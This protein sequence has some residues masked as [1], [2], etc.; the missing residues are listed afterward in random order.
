M[1]YQPRTLLALQLLAFRLMSS[2]GFLGLLSYL[3][4]LGYLGCS[5]NTPLNKLTERYATSLPSRLLA[6]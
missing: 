2:L 4:L 3:D 1:C 5:M 6:S